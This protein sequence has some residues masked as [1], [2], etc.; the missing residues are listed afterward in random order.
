M[1]FVVEK[2][3]PITIRVHV[4][5]KVTY[6]EVQVIL[7][8]VMSH[9]LRPGTQILVDALGVTGTPDASELRSIVRDL[10]PMIDA[11]LV[12]IAIVTDGFVYGVARM[13]S[14]FA[15]A[16]DLDVAVFRSMGEATEWLDSRA[17]PV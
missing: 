16:V 15:Q 4:S 2:A 7:A 1:P 9:G 13:F 12:A 17:T 11:G 8:E 6:A 5:G 3:D 14:V 10:V